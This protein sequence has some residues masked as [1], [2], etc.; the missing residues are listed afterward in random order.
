MHQEARK[1]AGR[2]E[3]LPSLL[4][5]DTHLARG[6]ALVVP[7][8]THEN[9]SNVAL[10]AQLAALGVTDRLD[11][12]MVNRGTTDRAARSVASKHRVEIRVNWVAREEPAAQAHR[13]RV[14]S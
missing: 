8:S 12:V 14:A 7:A 3:T 10:L 5:M 11:V 6:E 9:D 1:H 2:A 4:V 13:A